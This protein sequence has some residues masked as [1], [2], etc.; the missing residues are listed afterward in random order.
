VFSLLAVVFLSPRSSAELMTTLQLFMTYMRPH[1]NRS[2]ASEA[3]T[4]YWRRTK[5]W[6]HRVTS[7][8]AVSMATHV[9]KENR[10][11]NN[12]VIISF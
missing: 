1:L 10:P 9:N 8:D 3:I 5:R 2:A 6:R 4:L 7:L 11:N 12:S